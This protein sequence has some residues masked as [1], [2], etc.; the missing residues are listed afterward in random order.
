ML[1]RLSRTI[2]HEFEQMPPGFGTE[3]Q[4]EVGALT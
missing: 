4:L 2:Q 3:N 1:P